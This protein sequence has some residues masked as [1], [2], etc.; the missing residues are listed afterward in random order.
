[1]LKYSEFKP[2]RQ[3]KQMAYLIRLT[4]CSTWCS[5]KT[6]ITNIFCKPFNHK[7]LHWLCI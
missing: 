6:K 1:M 3:H 2:A 5:L 7:N 4:T